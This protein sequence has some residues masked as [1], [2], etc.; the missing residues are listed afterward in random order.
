[1]FSNIVSFSAPACT[2][3]LTIDSYQ[4]VCTSSGSNSA[5]GSSSPISITG[6]SGSTSYT[7]KVRAHNSKGYGSYSSSTGTATTSTAPPSAIGAAYQGG[8]YAGSISTAG[9]GIADYYLVIGPKST[10]QNNYRYQ[11]FP[12]TS[13]PGATSRVDGAANSTA[14]NDSGHPAAYFSKGLTVGGYSDWYLPAPNELEIVYYNLKPN[15]TANYTG[16]GANPNAVPARSS[17]YT[18]G[19]PASNPAQTSVAI[20]QLLGGQCMDQT[21][22]WTSEEYNAG[23]AYRQAF[24]TGNQSFIYKD[25]YVN[26]RAMR[27]VAV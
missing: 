24:D 20:F 18:G 2:G 5:T 3:H 23:K 15:V 9:N 27:K 16:S 19:N 25:Y 13:T 12:T 22:Y 6:L 14:L 17:N 8:Y 21:N 4:V 11:Y 1:M 7:F 26:L 10:T